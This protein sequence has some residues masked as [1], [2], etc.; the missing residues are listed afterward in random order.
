MT[1]ATPTVV[2]FDVTQDDIDFGHRVNCYRCP[3]AL[4]LKRHFPE[5]TFVAVFDDSVKTTRVFREPGDTWYPTSESAA[6]W[7]DFIYAFDED[8]PVKPCR[9]A[10]ERQTA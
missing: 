6:A 2:E 8:Q 4:A 9:L 1:T 10:I 3:I 5:N 7:K